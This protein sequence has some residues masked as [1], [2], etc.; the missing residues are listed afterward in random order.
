MGHFSPRSLAAARSRTVTR[1]PLVWPPYRAVGRLSDADIDTSKPRG[2]A[3]ASPDD[4]D[5][6]T[7]ATERT[8]LKFPGPVSKR[9]RCVS[10]GRDLS[11]EAFR[12]ATA[13]YR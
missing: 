4:I 13:S 2:A 12:N 7:G 9:D 3:L 11:S 1:R 6:Y 5:D 8:P 10:V